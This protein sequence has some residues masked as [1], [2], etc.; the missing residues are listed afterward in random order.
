MRDQL[1]QRLEA[2]Q[3]E[4]TA[5]LTRLSA[6]EL[7][8]TRLREQ[9]LHRAGALAELEALLHPIVATQVEEDGHG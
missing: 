9:I 3:T 8:W 6:L 4:Q 2:L 5:A 7:E 1:Q